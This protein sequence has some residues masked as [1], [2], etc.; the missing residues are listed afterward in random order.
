[1]Q[2]LP[3]WGL[4]RGKESNGC[5]TPAL[6]ETPRRRGLKWLYNPWHWALKSG[7]ESN[8]YTRPTILGI[9]KHALGIPTQIGRMA[10]FVGIYLLW[11]K[12]ATR[13]LCFVL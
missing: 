6:L 11:E 2:S 4:Q 7:E 13:V 12:K 9:P 3:F 5:I 10:A 1:M 8:G